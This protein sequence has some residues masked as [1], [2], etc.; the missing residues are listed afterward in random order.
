MYRYTSNIMNHHRRVAGARAI[1]EVSGH[2][3][4]WLAGGYDLEIGY[5]LEV[6]SMALPGG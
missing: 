4:R 3:F 6:A 5:F 1:I 2:Q